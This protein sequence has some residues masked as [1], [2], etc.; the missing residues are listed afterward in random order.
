[1]I[2]KLSTAVAS[3]AFVFLCALTA[4]AQQTTLPPQAQQALGQPGAAARVQSMIQNSGMTPDQIRDRLRVEGYPDSLLN[5]YLGGGAVDSTAVP[6]DAVF[7]AM[8]VLGL[9]DS[10]AVDSLRG[11]SRRQRGFA[12]RSDSAF[13]D[14]LTRAMA[15]DTTREALRR[16][17]RSHDAQVAVPDSGFTRFGMDVFQDTRQFD[18]NS[19]GPVDANYRFVPGDQLTLFL[20]GDVEKAYPLTV[21][22]EGFV[23]IPD[24]GQ[25]QVAGLSKA[26]LDDVL[27]TRLGTVYS[28]VR[29]HGATTF[30]SVNVS[31]LGSN[32]VFV[33][34]DVIQPSSYRVSSLA[35]VMT[36]IYAAQGPTEN[37]TMRN[38]ILRR[39][40]EVVD[41]VDLYDYLLNG[42]ASHDARLQNGDI[43]FV[44]AR[45]PQV[46]IAGAVL[47]PATYEIKPTETL[48]DLIRMSG[49][50][51]ATAD[52]SR[53]Q[54][55]R[56]IPPAQRTS[57]GAARRTID[58]ASALL[59]TSDGPPEPL[60]NGDVVRVLEIPRRYANRVNV[61]GNVWAPGPVGFTPGMHLS[62]ALRQAGGLK[63]DSYL[64]EIQLTRVRPDSS[65][66]MLRTAANDTTGSVADDFTLAD[67]DQIQVFS[68]TDFRP[69]RYV[70]I[71]GAVKRPGRV[72][73]RDGMTMRDLVLL[74]GGVQ[75]SALLTEAEIARIPEDRGNGVTA[76]TERV[77][78]DSTYLFERTANGQYQGPPGIAAPSARAP[79]VP[80]KPYDAVLI[81]RQPDWVLQRTVAI[82]GEVRYPGKYALTTKTETLRDLI[83]RAGGLTR[84]A[85]A[86]GIAFV[87]DSVG[88][89][90]VDLPDVLSRAGSVDNLPLVDGDSIFIPSFTPVVLVKGE[91]NSPI[92]VAYVRGADVDYYIRAAGGPTIKADMGR[93]YV[94][95][96][97]G[98]IESKKHH[99][100]WADAVPKPQP[101][102]TVT[103]PVKDPTHRTDW[104]AI[105]TSATSILGALVA[106]SA[107]IK[108]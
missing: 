108:K 67:G 25:V 64:G 16:L 21:T 46:R 88:R 71:T 47:R 65:R 32:Q 43:V 78:L 80:L 4:G 94:A 68:V 101:G 102:S 89:I 79:E 83:S 107:L 75:E 81:L 56:I 82:A 14:T 105:A 58:V 38:V 42:D 8:R 57:T 63:P 92:G 27:Y 15:N 76:V 26:Q 90:G 93:A 29:R 95:Q 45:G 74:A 104:A 24:V 98:K 99:A 1:M 50:F 59:A 60:K 61:A 66:Y 87:R 72:P 11:T 39:A 9:G 34:G 100:L 33:M 52:R 103:V 73:Y 96:P 70:T 48:A 6:S 3:A 31:K 86:G 97:N 28:G 22:R 49:G 7:D 54:I 84:Y 12:A 69:N 13:L 44:P 55:D 41:T 10:L 91:V 30:F 23:V 106:I 2:P 36:A 62:Q 35:T 17:L 19:A 20:T 53:V 40:G 37:G 5:N 85:Y 51:S 77:P 18:A